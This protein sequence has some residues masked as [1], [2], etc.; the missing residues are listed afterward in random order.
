[1]SGP[2]DRWTSLRKLTTD[3]IDRDGAALDLCCANGFLLECILKWTHDRGIVVTP[4]GLDI[5][6]ELIALARTGLPAYRYNMFSGNS[7]VWLSP[8]QMDYLSAMVGLLPQQYEA[9][10]VQFVVQNGCNLANGVFWH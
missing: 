3:C 9:N 4:Y 6:P 8:T 2:L 1:M 5:S 7:Y 10:F